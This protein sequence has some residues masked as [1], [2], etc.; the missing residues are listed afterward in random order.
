V[1]VESGVGGAVADVFALASITG[2]PVT[3]AGFHIAATVLMDNLAKSM[4][5]QYFPELGLGEYP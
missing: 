1:G 5:E 3:A 4:N 2:G